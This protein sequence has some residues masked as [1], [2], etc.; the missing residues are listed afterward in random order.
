MTVVLLAAC[1]SPGGGGNTPPEVALAFEQAMVR[2]SKMLVST[3]GG[4]DQRSTNTLLYKNRPVTTG[5]TYR[6]IRKSAGLTNEITLAADGTVSFGRAA[7]AKVNADGPLKVTIQA[8]Y[9]GKTTT[10][11]FML[12]DHFSGREVNTATAVYNDT[13]YIVGGSSGTNLRDV[14][15]STDAGSTF[16]KVEVTGS[17][18]HANLD[19]YRTVVA[20][21]TIYVTGGHLGTSSSDQNRVWKSTDGGKFWQELTTGTKFSARAS[22][23]TLAVGTDIYVIGS[24]F[25]SGGGGNQVWKSSDGDNWA[26]VTTSASTKFSGRDGHS[27]VYI[28]SGTNAGMYVIGGFSRLLKN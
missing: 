7:L 21:G 18:L 27:S 14:W 24:G 4:V 22:H 20:N 5:A 10:Y 13:L 28:P 11:D 25:G 9:Q 15:K 23:T 19:N 12:T 6:I 2:K 16:T 1:P 8:A 3:N 26:Q 17:F